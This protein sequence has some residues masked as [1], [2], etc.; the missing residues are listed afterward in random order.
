MS[1]AL[2]VIPYFEWLSPYLLTEHF[3]SHHGV[4][5]RDVDWPRIGT[6]LAY[7]G[8]YTVAAVAGTLAVFCRKDMTC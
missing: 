6:D 2:M 5:E 1:A 8:A 4:F 3:R 7:V